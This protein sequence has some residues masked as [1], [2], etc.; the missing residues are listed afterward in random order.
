MT[1][2]SLTHR[3]A[4]TATGSRF[5]LRC[6]RQRKEKVCAQR[7]GRTER[8]RARSEEHTSEL[9]SHSDL[10]SFPTRRSS[11]LRCENCYWIKVPV[12]M[13]ETEEGKSVCTTCWENG[14]KKG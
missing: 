1:A 14:K 6:K 10:H 3:D 4:K 8:K 7:A 2:A 5:Q 13:Q 9:Q 11:D 12:E